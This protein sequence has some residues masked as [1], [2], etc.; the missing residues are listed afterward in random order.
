MTNPTQEKDKR[1][2]KLGNENYYAWS[3]RMEMRLRKL[4][5]WSL[6]DGSE[7][8]PVGSDNTKV[9][10]AWRTRMDLAL[11]E[12]VS[13]VEDGQLVHTRF[14]RDPVEV[15]K[16]LKSVHQSEGLG[17]AISIWQRLFMMKKTQETSIQEHASTIREIADRLTGLGDKPSDTL[18]V[19]ILMLSLPPSYSSLVISLDSHSNKNDFDFVVH[20]CMNEEARQ[21]ATKQGVPGRKGAENVAFH[22]DLKPRRDRKDITCFKCQKKGHYQNECKEADT[23]KKDDVAKV[24]IALSDQDGIVEW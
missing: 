7:S 14:S 3:Y 17:S 4:G 22:A 5:V 9:V 10:K 8:R 24:A 16:R 1:V 23:P 2:S 11:C 12:I 20:R 6:V 15:W 18:L 13:E 21:V 19:A